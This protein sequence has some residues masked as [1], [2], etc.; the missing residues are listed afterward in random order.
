MPTTDKFI[1]RIYKPNENKI[2]LIEIERDYFKQYQ[3][4]YVYA[5]E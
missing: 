5:M 3:Y 1:G 2:D 4:Y